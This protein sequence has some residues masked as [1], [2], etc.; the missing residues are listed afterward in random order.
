MLCSVVVACGVLLLCCVLCRYMMPWCV[1]LL[2]DVDRATSLTQFQPMQPMLVVR[3]GSG[4]KI[5]AVAV[6]GNYS[7]RFA[8]ACG[9]SYN[10]PNMS[11]SQ[12]YT[13]S[14]GIRYQ[15]FTYVELASTSVK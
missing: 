15:A 13:Q 5:G 14:D 7:A 4:S 11:V 6:A 8:T 10:Y 9:I 2:C 1:A 12:A 3:D